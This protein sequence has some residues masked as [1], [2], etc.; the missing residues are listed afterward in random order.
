M[1]DMTNDKKIQALL[2]IIAKRFASSADVSAFEE[3]L[4]ELE[5]KIQLLN[6]R[7]DNIQDVE[8][9]DGNYTVTPSTTSDQ[10]LQTANL[11]MEDDVTV[12]E[13]PFF[14]VGNI[15]GGNTVYI[16]SDIE[17]F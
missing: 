12:K 2:Q 13:I 17:L 4:K 8:T 10:V 1:L 9:Y 3:A 5:E 15:A 16:G 14:E 6:D 11:M 7:V